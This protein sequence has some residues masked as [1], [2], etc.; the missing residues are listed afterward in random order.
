[1]PAASPLRHSPIPHGRAAASRPSIGR[2][3]TARIWQRLLGLGPL[4]IA[5]LLGIT[6]ILSA[7]VLP[8]LPGQLNDEP[9]A[10]SRWLATT[11]ANY[12]VWG[13]PLQIIGLFNVLHSP[14][15]EAFFCLVILVATVHLARDLAR[16]R[17]F[18]QLPAR[19]EQ[20]V[21]DPGEPVGL[22]AGE[23]IARLRAILPGALDNASASLA[24]WLAARFS[25]IHQATVAYSA[26]PDQR[27]DGPPATDQRLLAL[28]HLPGRYLAPLFPLGIILTAGAVWFAATFGWQVQTPALAPGA[29]FR[30]V[31]QGLVI[32]HLA[33]TDADAADPAGADAEITL[34]SE[35]RQVH[36]TRDVS[37]LRMGGATA[38]L[39]HTL[40]ALWIAAS[41]G[42]A[43]L[44]Q[45][46]GSEP[47]AELGLVFPTAGGE[48]SVLLPSEVAGLRLVRRTDLPD[49]FVVELY[50]STDVQ[51]SLRAEVQLPD[52]LTIPLEDGGELLIAPVRALQADIYYYP[53]LWLA[54]L[55]IAASLVGAA[56][57]LRPARFL[58]L[59]VAPWPNATGV[60]VAQA[61]HPPDIDALR[62]LLDLAGS[63]TASGG[64]SAA[65]PSP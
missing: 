57:H 1:M 13:S 8:Q 15:L 52:S 41:D 44:T 28:H 4:L 59:Q 7:W 54:W 5:V 9:A 55:G 22:Y 34:R 30:S 11:A 39:R 24:E 20:P 27:A 18:T 29:S 38:S 40:P 26:P 51:P 42:A 21:T 17:L 53:G 65:Q 3:V 14:L 45:T 23:P 62:P 10:A 58:L 61:S 63:E 48:E 49:A 12:G 33:P 25:T 16:L 50:R 43:L 46:D 56:G 6:L 31:N 64:S 47:V 32:H 60:L 37:R 19:L 35:T 2:W 36:D